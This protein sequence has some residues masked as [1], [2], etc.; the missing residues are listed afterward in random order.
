MSRDDRIARRIALSLLC[1][2]VVIIAR[3]ALVVRQEA[4]VADAERLLEAP[5]E[6]I[7]GDAGFAT[8]FDGKSRVPRVKLAE[9][10]FLA[11]QSLDAPTAADRRADLERA[12]ADIG[13]ATR[14]R[15]HWGDA[16]TVRAFIETQR[17]GEDS[18]AARAALSRSYADAP[19]L[20]PAGLWRVRY[21]LEQWPLLDKAS[22]QHVVQEADWLTRIDRANRE[23]IFALARQS[24]GYMPLLLY[25]R[26]LR[27]GDS[28]FAR[29][30][31]APQQ[32]D[33][34]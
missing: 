5:S 3:A 15:P 18:A 9:A 30:S 21:G 32:A 25:W 29:Q 13:L 17:A 22:R 11:R 26:T 27:A 7:D 23:P 14:S 8:V 10:S 6:M 33:Q 19:F 24:A 20:R 34:K 16:W 12:A 4:R 28:D 2:L 1:V 31:A